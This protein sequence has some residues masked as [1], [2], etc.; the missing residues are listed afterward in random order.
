LSFITKKITNRLIY[1]KI[2]KKVKN[3]LNYLFIKIILDFRFKKKFIQYF[4]YNWKIID[5]K[6][7]D[8]IL[9]EFLLKL[10]LNSTI[11]QTILTKQYLY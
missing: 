9:R 2:N 7:F 3:L 5:K 8:N 6:K 10:L 4:K 11:K 1:Y